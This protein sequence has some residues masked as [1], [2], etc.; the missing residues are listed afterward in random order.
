VVLAEESEC[1][2]C[3]ELVDKALKFPDPM[4]PAV[5]HIVSWR[6]GG[7]WYDRANLRL[8]HFVCNSTGDNRPKVVPMTPRQRSVIRSMKAEHPAA[9]VDVFGVAV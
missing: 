6:E 1:G 3:G 7:S 2:F 8:A 9:L 4:S 5:D